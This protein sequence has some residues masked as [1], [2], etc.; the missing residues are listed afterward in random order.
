VPPTPGVFAAMGRHFDVISMNLYSLFSD[1]L[2]TQMF[3]LL[4]LVHN[5]TKKPIMTSEFTFR[6]GD[7]RCPN[8]IGAPPTVPTQADRAVGY[9]SYVSAVASLPFHVGVSWYQYA[10]DNPELPW[11]G[12]AED[13]NFGAVD[14]VRRPYASLV[15]T[16]RLVNGSIYELAADPVPNPKC[17][18]FYRTELMRWDRAWDRQIFMRFGQMETPPL[19]PLGDQLPEPRRYHEHYWVRHKSP[20]LVI[21]DDGYYGWSS[22]NVLRTLDD[23]QELA[24]LGLQGFCSVP[25]TS[26]FGPKCETPTRPF[27]VDSN[28]QMFLRRIDGQGRVRRMTMIGGSFVLTEFSNFQIRTNCKCPYIDVA[29]DPDG[30][31]LAITSQGQ[32]R[33]VGI[34]DVTGW[35]A[36]WNGHAV[37]AGTLPNS[38]DI[39]SFTAP[40]P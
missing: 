22:A 33:N 5:F 35:Q 38:P 10:D 39:S 31:K 20:K 6:G 29:Y 8:T 40:S 23:G 25:R 14:N 17:P 26:W 19:D 32:V 34:R 12:Y 30:K 24:M 28:A 1:R 27:S 13:C 21:N 15:S 11:G 9:L 37:T 16:M 4:P 18:L 36:I 3:T 7:T 2:L